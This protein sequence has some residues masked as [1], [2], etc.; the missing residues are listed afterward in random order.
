MNEVK[1]PKG[2][3]KTAARYMGRLE[4]GKKIIRTS[5]NRVMWDDGRA[6]GR[7]TLAYML[8]ERMIVPHDTDL[9]GDPTRGQTLGLPP[10]AQEAVQ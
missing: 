8:Q 5:D 1:I 4:A 2:V 10:A 7:R 6:V 9:F 3:L